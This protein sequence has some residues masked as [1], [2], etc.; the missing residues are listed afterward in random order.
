MTAP[1]R[2]VLRWHGGKWKLAPWILSYFPAHRVYVEAFGGAASLLIR[3]PRVYGEVYN[4][5]DSEV[6]GLFRVLRDDAQACKL[7]EQLK[8]TPFSRKEFE[9]CY[10]KARDPIEQA[11]RLVV[12]SYMGFGSNAHASDDSGRLQTGFR[13]NSNRSGTTPAQDWA[14]Y[15]E[16]LALIVARWRGVTVENRHGCA[17]MRQ[18]DGADTLHYVDP[19]YMPETRS[20]GNPCC[21]KSMYRH[22]LDR[23]GHIR[24]LKCLRSLTG[25]VVL[26]GYPT[27]LYDETLADWLRVSKKAHADGARARTEVL[28]LNPACAAAVN[29]ER[30]QLRLFEAA[31]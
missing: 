6:V 28:W 7:I 31:E 8:L 18:H 21:K 20:I 10:R 16:A 3:K 9:L 26:S 23:G 30:A 12:R 13:G 1:T 15:P 14:N 27:E 22:E 17:V 29:R 25:F 4:D 2:P 19:P 11:R 24:L 5:L